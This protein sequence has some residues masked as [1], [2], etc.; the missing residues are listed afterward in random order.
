MN[1]GIFGTPTEA[2]S[3]SYKA[4]YLFIFVFCGVLWAKEECRAEEFPI[5]GN[6]SNSG[7]K[8]LIFE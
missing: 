5:L 7:I 6:F 4:C 8:P 2:A 1:S 3:N